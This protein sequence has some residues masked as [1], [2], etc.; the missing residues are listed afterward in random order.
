MEFDIVLLILLFYV[1]GKSSSWVTNSLSGLGA[2]MRINKFLM[3]L[4][5]LGIATSASEFLVAINAI[6]TKVPALSL[7]N[8]LGASFVLLTLIAGF[9]VFIS[10]Q[11][12]IFKAISF[13]ELLI[14]NTVILLPAAL[15]LDGTLTRTDG[16]ILILA[17][18]VYISYM[19]TR[20]KI[21]SN[22]SNGLIKNRGKNSWEMVGFLILGLLVMTVAAKYAVDIGTE[23]AFGLG[24]SPLVV[25]ILLFSIGTNLPE[26]VI[27]LEVGK[28][29]RR[30]ILFGDLLGSSAANSL[31]IGLVAFF[32][33][34]QVTNMSF[35]YLMAL[36]LAG[37]VLAF[38]IMA[39]TK[40]K[41]VRE[42]GF[43]LMGIYFLFV[44]AAIFLNLT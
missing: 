38:N 4:V 37:G 43:L 24:I 25:G 18:A 44:A 12:N 26:L 32:Q 36:F 27:A 14:L 28:S 13:K 1:L 41:L 40:N 20:K 5:V 19:V 33:P 30:Y 39:L 31:V 6:A 35:I 10:K 2:K 15:V 29:Q 16:M 42:E 17:F 9:S 8:V 23:L 7:G 11:V 22:A 3:G 34:I 21:F